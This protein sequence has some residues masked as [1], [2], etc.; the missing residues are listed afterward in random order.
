MNALST[1]TSQH[2]VP[3]AP[4]FPIPMHWIDTTTVE[5]SDAPCTIESLDVQARV[6]GLYADVAETLVIHNPNER[7][8]SASLAI[9][10]PD[11]A[12]VCGYAL[13]I[14][15]QLVDGVV[16]PKDEARIAFETEQRIGT[17]PGLVEAVKDNIY[18]TRVYPIPKGSTR[19]VQLRYTAPLTLTGGA[20][21][22]LDLPMPEGQLHK[23]TLCIDVE[24]IGAGDPILLEASGATFGKAG[25]R[26]HAESEELDVSANAGVRFVLPKLPESFAVIERDENG[27]MW[28]A[29]S[30]IATVVDSIDAPDL[31]AITVIWDTSGSRAGTDHAS[32]LELL[33]A[34][35]A[36][37]KR[38]R[39]VAFADVA[40]EAVEF[41]SV[42]ALMDRIG[43][44]RYDGATDFRNLHQALSEAPATPPISE[45]EVYVLFTDGMATISEA[46]APLPRDMRIVAIVSGSTRDAEFLRQT[47]NGLVYDVDAAPK[48]TEGL[49]QA[50][51][52]PNRL[53]GVSGP[54]VSEVLGIGSGH[55]GRYSIAGK[56]EADETTIAFE[57]TGTVFH[58]AAENA[59]EGSTLSRAW[60]AIRVAQLSPHADEHADELLAL[61]RQFGLSSP[62]TS[63]LVLETLDQY[64]RYEIEPPKT[65]KRMH[66][67]WERHVGGIMKVS[68]EQGMKDDHVRNL[69][70]AWAD[71]RE[72]WRKDY[73][74]TQPAEDTGVC[75]SCGYCAG[76]DARFCPRCGTTM[77]ND[78]AAVPGRTSGTF[79]AGASFTGAIADTRVFA[80]ASIDAHDFGE[81]EVMAFAEDSALMDAI[82]F[83]SAE[84]AYGLPNDEGRD[85]GNGSPA[86]AASVTVQAWMPD[87]DYLVALDDALRG[88][89][90]AARNAYHDVRSKHAASPSFFIDCA[91]WFMA[92]GDHA[93]GLKVL[94]NL[95][96]MR[97]EDAALLRVMAWRLREAGELER[98]LSVLRR[99]LKLRPEDSQSHR[100]VALVLDELARH[101]Y[102]EGDADK[103]RACAEEAGDFYRNVA[104]TPWQRRAEAVSLFA[105]EEYNV[106]RA[107]ADAQKWGTA[108][109]LES[110]GEGLDD[111]FDCDL[112]VTLAWDAD[113]TDIDLHVTEPS[114]EEAYYGHR[115]THA[116]GR[117][118]E[119]ITDGYGPELYAIRRALDGEY[120]VRA[121]YYASHQ[122]TIFGPASCT[123][124]VYTDWG[125]PTQKQTVT[126]TR[127]ENE[128]EMIHVGVAAYGDAAR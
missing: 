22:V 90:D 9:P 42:D 82:A 72:W 81:R 30:E 16:V 45:N 99:V 108:P 20:E 29:A 120:V 80:S 7:D 94:S 27:S 79:G 37:A 38:I 49:A 87:A 5:S 19:T 39:L 125:R 18:R 35:C 12:V 21:A 2:F 113:E 86:T 71:L 96:E 61:G 66:Q 104:F 109:K 68:S 4:A 48:H 41:S 117:V 17:D 63:L 76:A 91:G 128:K 101:A 74:N 24:M 8:I 84:P 85:S 70:R 123:L 75:P 115:L 119:D 32:E 6:C 23:R 122:Q 78:N 106:L 95:A 53:T 52:H 51:F 116:G 55:D 15:G 31:E 3:R 88:G 111:V 25:A 59:R 11:G 127:L 73:S 14:D 110:L 89:R 34:Y 98:A 62:A 50:V 126:S 54:G 33:R 77:P 60:A 67:E 103:A 65:W 92:N 1:Q 26:W 64:L 47:C 112:R 58:L 56:L 13:D 57:N 93:F 97:V 102:D 100:D 69:K 10:M 118:S 107:W 114:G 44:L 28:F 124:T 40:E 36:Q 83:A 43:S 121:H 46:P 105:V